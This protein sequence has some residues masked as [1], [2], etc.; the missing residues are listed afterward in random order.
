MVLLPRTGQGWVI[1][2][3]G[4]DWKFDSFGRLLDRPDPGPYDLCWCGSG[5]KFR[6]CHRDR[7]KLPRI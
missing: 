4:E 1:E 5:N 3:N 2:V 7:H 6:F